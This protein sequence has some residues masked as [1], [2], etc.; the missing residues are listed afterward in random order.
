MGMSTCCTYSP[1]GTRILFGDINGKIIIRDAMNGK[2]I[3]E[4]KSTYTQGDVGCCAWSSSGKYIVTASGQQSPILWNARTGTF[5]NWLRNPNGSI[6]ETTLISCRFSPDESCI[7][8]ISEA[9]EDTLLRTSQKFT[10]V[11]NNIVFTRGDQLILDTYDDSF[12]PF[13]YF[14]RSA[15]FSSDG[16]QI[17]FASATGFV[18]IFNAENLVE[19]VIDKPSFDYDKIN[20]GRISHRSFSP[21]GKLIAVINRTTFTVEIWDIRLQ[22]LHKKIKTVEGEKL[23]SC[24]FSSDGKR[25]LCAYK[26]AYTAIIIDV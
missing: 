22:R 11:E 14:T 6:F 1:D 26:D 5:L 12:A 4:L 25:I 10:F 20:Y 8:M 17:A 21:D 24:E 16:S 9:D 15:I 3:T 19:F 18:R 13:D 23:S 7:L 2:Q